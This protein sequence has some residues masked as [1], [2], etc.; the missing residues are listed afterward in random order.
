MKLLYRGIA[1]EINGQSGP[2]SKAI[3]PAI[4]SQK[5]CRYRGSTYRRQTQR[6]PEAHLAAVSTTT[7]M[8]RGHSYERQL[9]AFS[10]EQPLPALRSDWQ[11]HPQA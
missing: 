4:Q 9:P 1:Y 5:N 3:E 6:Q 7:L 10:M 11:L 8:Y 2:R